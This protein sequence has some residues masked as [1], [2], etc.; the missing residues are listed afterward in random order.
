MLVAKFVWWVF[1]PSDSDVYV[2]LSNINAYDNSGKFIIN[3]NPFGVVLAPPPP[4]SPTI[5]SE[6]TLTGLYLG[7]P[8]SSIAFY[9]LKNKPYIAKIGDSIPDSSAIVKSI[10]AKGMVVSENNVDVDINIGK[11]AGAAQV[12]SSSSNT[13]SQNNFL[14]NSQSGGYGG[15]SLG[16]NQAQPSMS[17]SNENS[18]RQN[19]SN[20]DS[21]SSD[22]VDKRRKMIEDFMQ[23]RNAESANTMNSSP[24]E[25][26]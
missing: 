25:Y 18:A 17:P 3:R 5:A 9:E 13:N 16:Q 7:S 12:V 24:Q 4:P 8:A 2:E 20:Q 22:L 21:Q 23:R 15:S 6:I 11:G 14:N 19:N 1:S 10:T 26:H